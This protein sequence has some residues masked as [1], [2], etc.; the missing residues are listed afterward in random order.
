MRA[1]SHEAL[2]SWAKKTRS[3]SEIGPFSIIRNPRLDAEVGVFDH[4]TLKMAERAFVIERG[5][6]PKTYGELLGPY[7]KT[8]PDGIGPQDLVNPG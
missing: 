5:R 2:E 7:L 6:P 3:W 1:I 4:F 8:L